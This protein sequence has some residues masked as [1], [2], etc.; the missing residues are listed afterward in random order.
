MFLIWNIMCPCEYFYHCSQTVAKTQIN[1]TKNFYQL[2][3]FEENEIVSWCFSSHIN[4][5]LINTHDLLSNSELFELIQWRLAFIV[6]TF[7][8]ECRWSLAPCVNSASLCLSGS[9]EARTGLFTFEFTSQ[10]WPDDLGSELTLYVLVL[11]CSW[12]EARGTPAAVLGGLVPSSSDGEPCRWNT[13]WGWVAGLS[14]TATKQISEKIHCKTH[15][16]IKY[17]VANSKYPS[18]QVATG[19]CPF[20]S[21]WLL[22]HKLYRHWFQQIT[23]C[24]LWLHRT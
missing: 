23:G 6:C 17:Y 4:C 3:L 22:L 8:T 2:H 21:F 12:A 19:K 7:S 10:P 14:Y 13:Y 16:S 1:H 9:Q 11:D 5:K 18:W 24:K 15:A 20:D